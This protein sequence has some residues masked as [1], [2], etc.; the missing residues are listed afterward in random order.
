MC[1]HL[2]ANE[3]PERQC[4]WKLVQGLEVR[5]D[6][7]REH[8]VVEYGRNKEDKEEMVEEGWET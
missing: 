7:F 1:C 4:S 2:S 3:R 5:K 8:E 6:L